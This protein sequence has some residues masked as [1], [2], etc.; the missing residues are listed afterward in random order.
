MEKIKAGFITVFGALFSWLGIL[1]IPVFMLVGMNFIDYFTGLAAAKYRDEKVT[2]YKSIR[3][4]YKKVFMWVLII[5]GWGM[6]ILINYTVKYIGLDIKVPFI[7]ATLV[8]VW[9][10]C[11]EVISTLENL[12]DIGVNIPPFL[13]PLAKLIKGKVEDKAKIE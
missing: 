8:A 10:I 6:D 9:L 12:I 5:I 13:M 7:V 11:N 4:I 1:A 3:G 2:S